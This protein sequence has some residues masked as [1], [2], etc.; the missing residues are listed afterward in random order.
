MKKENPVLSEKGFA[1]L[2][3]LVYAACTFA[4]VLLHD[5]WAD[6]AQAWLLARD[7]SPIGL[8]RQMR[9]EGS[10]ALWHFILMPFAKAGFPYF[11]EFVV[12]WFIAASMVFVFLRYS[13]FSRLTKALFTFSYF[14]FYEYV[15]IA[16]SYGLSVL[17]LFLIAAVYKRRFERP[18]LFALLVFLLFN[19]NA[20]SFGAA[21]AL[22]AIFAYDGLMIRKNKPVAGKR[23]FSFLFLAPVIMALGGLA[24]YLQV[25]HPVMIPRLALRDDLRKELFTALC[26]AFLYSYWRLD[27]IYIRSAFVFIFLL[28]TFLS[29]ARRIQPLFF[30]LASYAALSTIF[31]LVSWAE[32]SQYGY[33]LIFVVFTLWI[34]GEYEDAAFTGTVSRRLPEPRTMRRY[35]IALLNVSLAIGVLFGLYNLAG[36]YKYK[37]SYAGE[38]AGFMK[39][40]GLAAG[41]IV[42]YQSPACSS[43]LPFLDGKAFWYPDIGAYGTFISWNRKFF[44]SKSGSWG[45]A[46]LTASDILKKAGERFG[47]DPDVYLLLSR[48]VKVGG[49]A[50]RHLELIYRT[51]GRCIKHEET[52]SLYRII[53]PRKKAP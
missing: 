23:P 13:P 17:L 27:N 42:A 4:G 48:D 35:S 51:D 9:Y 33:F 10:P 53:W 46:S 12:H 43:V 25:R 39:R 41:T 15:I 37:L 49:P 30:L 16:R 28:V 44:Q 34:S 5:P 3:T 24:V 19:T 21:A 14:I 40:H 36:F 38:M 8:L 50:R 1:V 18:L 6:E 45:T 26:N 31:L 20:H 29:V 22:A 52:Y 7:L 47:R 32:P 11:T 2:L